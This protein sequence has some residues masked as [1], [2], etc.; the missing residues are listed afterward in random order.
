MLV[1]EVPHVGGH[2]H[3]EPHVFGGGP[4]GLLDQPLPHQRAAQAEGVQQGVQRESLL[5]AG[6]A[7]PP[8]AAAGRVAGAAR[9]EQ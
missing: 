3:E 9:V 5:G 2:V 7:D 1:D 6:G 4:G 8:G